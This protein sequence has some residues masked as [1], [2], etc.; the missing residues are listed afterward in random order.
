[1]TQLL[2]VDH[3]LSVPGPVGIVEGQRKQ[4]LMVNDQLLRFS[5]MYSSW[6]YHTPE[7]IENNKKFKLMNV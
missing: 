4:G 2:P 5:Y 6:R 3:N 1:M 7:I